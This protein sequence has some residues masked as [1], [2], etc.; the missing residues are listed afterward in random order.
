[1][2]AISQRFTARNASPGKLLHL[3]L[4]NG[5]RRKHFYES[6][7]IAVFVVRHILDRRLLAALEDVEEFD[8]IVLLNPYRLWVLH[9][10]LCPNNK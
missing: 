5:L 10:K 8:R 3:F 9:E 6:L 2:P 4:V 7:E 1:M